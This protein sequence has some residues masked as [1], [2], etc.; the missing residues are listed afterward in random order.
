MKIPVPP[1]LPLLM[2]ATAL[3][4]A[5]IAGCGGGAGNA[6][7]RA[8]ATAASTTN[9][10]SD[11]RRRLELATTPGVR[12]EGGHA[13]VEMRFGVEKNPLPGE[14]FRVTI[15]LLPGEGAPTLKVDVPPSDGLEMSPIT[16]PTVFDKV[17]PGAIYTVPVE[18]RSATVGVRII[19]VIATEATPTGA[20]TAT[21]TFPVIVGADALAG[22]APAT[23]TGTAAKPAAPAPAPGAPKS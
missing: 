21:Y 6:A 11:P 3:L 12:A 13:A 17:E 5:T 20:D 9:T 15:A 2:G 4:V 7:K 18:F 1:T 19:T 22:S 8:A 23:A 14:P 10:A 16:A